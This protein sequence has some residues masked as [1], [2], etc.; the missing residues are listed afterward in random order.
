MLTYLLSVSS[1]CLLALALRSSWRNKLL[2][3]GPK[4]TF[5]IG[6]LFDVPG[7]AS[8]PWKVYAEWGKR[9]GR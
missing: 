6:N 5:L 9:Y 1:I 7:D 3:P 8:S 4:P 2:P